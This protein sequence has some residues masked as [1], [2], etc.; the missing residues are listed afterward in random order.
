MATQKSRSRSNGRS[1]RSKNSRSNGSG[2]SSRPASQK[3][4]I[5]LTTNRDPSRV[6]LQVR[7]EL[8]QLSRNRTSSPY[9][10]NYSRFER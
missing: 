6:A 9:V 5:V 1:S 7:D 3:V 2:G 8:A 4:E 10:P